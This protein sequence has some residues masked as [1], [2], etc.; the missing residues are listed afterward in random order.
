MDMDMD[1]LQLQQQ[2]HD[3]D[4]ATSSDCFS[5][6]WLLNTKTAA[7]H[8]HIHADDASSS[9]STSLDIDMKNPNYLLQQQQQQQQLQRRAA[10]C[11]DS[12]FNFPLTHGHDQPSL[13]CTLLHADQLFSN[14]LLM[15]IQLPSPPPPPQIFQTQTPPP[16]PAHHLFNSNSNSNSISTS[17]GNNMPPSLSQFQFSA[18]SSSQ[19][20]FLAD[21]HLSPSPLQSSQEY[22][23]KYCRRSRCWSSKRIFHKY[24]GFFLRPLYMYRKLITPLPPR[25][26]VNCVES[27]QA[28]PR[29]SCNITHDCCHTH[30]N[31]LFQSHIDNLIYEAVLHCKKSTDNNVEFD[32]N[33]KIFMYGD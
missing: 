18:S 4:L 3:D 30:T 10:A 31:F 33:F 22:K 28:T 25:P 15:P 21:H 27:L 32:F 20:L 9:S 2:Q 26:M 12:N 7:D 24:L 5:Y 14:G 19:N 29:T 11:S 17:N 13:T 1:A 23:S 8:H 6:R 16:P